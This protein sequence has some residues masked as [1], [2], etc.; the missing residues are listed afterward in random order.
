MGGGGEV[1][2]VLVYE[3]DHFKVYEGTNPHIEHEPSYKTNDPTKITFVYAWP[4][5]HPEKFE[6]MTKEQID[7]IRASSRLRN[8]IPWT[9]H[10]GQQAR[11]TS[12]RRIA[13]YLDLRPSARTVIERDMEREFGGEVAE[14][15]VTRASRVRERLAA[16]RAPQIE[17][18]T[19]VDAPGAD[20]E[21][22]RTAS[23]PPADS[24]SQAPK[25]AD[26]PTCGVANADVP[27]E[28]CGKPVDHDGPHA[29]PDLLL[30]W[31]KAVGK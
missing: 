27:T 10:Y 18:G 4:L 28:L 7:V 6:V 13:N 15:V 3:E 16:R 2:A 19:P 21:A 17:A 14:P 8:G 1:K 5:D 22:E 9:Q 20:D 31:P 26:Q 12:I 24:A 29:S 23:A 11:K 25:S 30:V